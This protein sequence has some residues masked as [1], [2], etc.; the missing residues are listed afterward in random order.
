[1][2][3]WVMV[4]MRS[5]VALTVLAL[6]LSASWQDAT[7]LLRR[8]GKLARALAS[9]NV[10]MP[11]FTAAMI[12]LF[13][14]RPAVAV[15]LITL[16]VSPIPP[17]LPRKALKAGGG[18]AYTIGLLA[19]ASLL[20]IVFVPLAVDLLGR[21]SGK[22]ARVS[23]VAVAQVVALTVLAPLAAG[24]LVRRLARAFAER[25]ARPAA[26][27]GLVLL[28]AGLVP[29]LV[30]TAPAI[31]PLLGNGTLA[32]ILA[33]DLVGLAAGYLLGGP[34]HEERTVLALTTSSRHPGVALVIAS[35]NVSDPKPVIGALVLY[36]LVNA[37]V[38][39]LY[40]AWSKRRH[41]KVPHAVAPAR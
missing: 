40:V 1:M 27:A 3:T 34:E 7:F 21:A 10:V 2:P 38:S 37:V 14:L 9:M 24:M 19:V 15:A 5:G 33:F 26:V 20:A 22:P 32:A 16:A 31:V 39:L 30:T 6:G 11:L 13:D 28:G 23:V 18:A 29:V 4:A 25:I 12:S 35:A 8:P 41:V 36:L 17:I